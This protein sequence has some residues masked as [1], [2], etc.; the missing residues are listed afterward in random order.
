MCLCMCKCMGI[1]AHAHLSVHENMTDSK[2]GSVIV[3][4][5]VRV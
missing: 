1:C 5:F 3:C 2:F 4:V